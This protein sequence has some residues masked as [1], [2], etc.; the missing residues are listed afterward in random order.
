MWTTENR[1]RYN[2]DRLRYPS[3]L[4]DEEWAL[5]GPLIPPA[6]RA[7]LARHLIGVPE[8]ARLFDDGSR[9]VATP[10]R[11]KGVRIGHWRQFGNVYL[12]LALWRGLGLEDLC[13]RLLPAGRERIAWGKMAAVL[14][15]ARFCEPSSELHI[16]EA[17][18]RRTAFCDLL[19]LA[20]E[21]INK[22]SSLSRARS[23]VSVG[24]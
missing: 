15:A 13:V 16:A 3:D 23:S 20:D 7:T 2:R 4:T 24:T 12:S 6:K 11:L 21:E 14:V 22:G 1:P 18:Y 10:I 19:Q 5:I 8:Q 9:E 17:W